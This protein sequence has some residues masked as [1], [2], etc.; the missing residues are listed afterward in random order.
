MLVRLSEGFGLRKLYLGLELLQA[1]ARSGLHVLGF[2]LHIGFENYRASCRAVLASIL[3][4]HDRNA[5]V[6]S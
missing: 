6:F 2:R 1:Q 5:G 4:R 3:R